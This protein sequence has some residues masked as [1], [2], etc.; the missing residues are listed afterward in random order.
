MKANED[1][2]KYIDMPDDLKNKYQYFTEAK[3]NKLR[4]IGYEESFF[5]LNL[6]VQD[7]VE[8]YLSTKDMYA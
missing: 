8:N 4:D 3:M 2:I 6:G 1:V 5:D 7:Y